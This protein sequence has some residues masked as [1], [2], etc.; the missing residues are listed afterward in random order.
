MGCSPRLLFHQLSPITRVVEEQTKVKSSLVCEAVCTT[1][2]LLQRHGGLIREHDDTI[3]IHQGPFRCPRCGKALKACSAELQQASLPLWHQDL[4]HYL[5]IV[6]IHG[7]P[8]EDRP[9]DCPCCHQN[10]RKP[11]RHS[12]YERLVMTLSYTIKICIFRFRCPDCGYVHSVIPAFLEP[13]MLLALDLQEELIEVV[14]QGVTV[15]KAAELAQTLLGGSLDEQTIGRLVRAWNERLAQ[16]QSGLW[17]WILARLP[18]ISLPRSGSLWNSLRRAW[19]TVRERIPAFREICFL[20][21]LN[22]L[23]FSMTVAEHG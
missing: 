3:R 12:H 8:E 2:G 17:E 21:G 14:E 20:H 18:H 7:L 10:K 1:N 23:H 22:H 4:E 5:K 13:Y 9:K 15:E 16:L 6:G 11:H 19:Q